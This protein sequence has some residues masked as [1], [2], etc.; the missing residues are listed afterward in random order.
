MYLKMSFRVRQSADRG[1]FQLTGCGR[2][3]PTLPIDIGV[4]RD[5]EMIQKYF[6][7]NLLYH[8]PCFNNSNIDFLHT[9]FIEDP[10]FG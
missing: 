3:P 4:S 9:D 5:D 2:D 6:Y 1:I 10:S 8:F 7:T